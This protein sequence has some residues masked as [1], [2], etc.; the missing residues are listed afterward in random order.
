MD[1]ENEE[2]DSSQ[3][4]DSEEDGESELSEGRSG[5]GG[6]GGDDSDDDGR[7]PGPRRRDSDESEEEEKVGNGRIEAAIKIVNSRNN[8]TNSSFE[9]AEP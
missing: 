2:G 7:P 4:Y 5:G 9:S 3:D 6:S 1:S 8:N